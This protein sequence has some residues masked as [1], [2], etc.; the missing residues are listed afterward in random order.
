M[1]EI[2]T[3]NIYLMRKRKKGGPTNRAEKKIKTLMATN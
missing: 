2:I 3:Q 1:I